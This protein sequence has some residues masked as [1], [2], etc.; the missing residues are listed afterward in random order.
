MPGLGL[1]SEISIARLVTGEQSPTY[2]VCL[3]FAHVLV[4]FLS[5]QADIEGDKLVA[6]VLQLLDSVW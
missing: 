1:V 5:S 3:G 6:S 2:I 4:T